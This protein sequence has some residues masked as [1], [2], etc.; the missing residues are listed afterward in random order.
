MK[1]YFLLFA[2]C[3]VSFSIQAKDDGKNYFAASFGIS[4][5]FVNM[6]EFESW[7]A[8]LKSKYVLSDFYKI[9]KS[10]I[11]PVVGF[12]IGKDKK[13]QTGLQLQYSFKSQSIKDSIGKSLNLFHRNLMLTYM[14]GY[15]LTKWFRVDAGLNLHN[16]VVNFKEVGNFYFNNR[17]ESSNYSIYLSP[18]IEL[19][20][21]KREAGISISPFYNLGINKFNYIKKGDVLA[22]QYAGPISSSVNSY[23]VKIQLVFR[24]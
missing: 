9:E 20:D 14:I 17:N 7:K 12:Y 2:I 23:G 6:P 3:L 11:M 5:A 13:M 10:N 19:L 24:K 16:N 4:T 18:T 22:T 1:N 15:N 21:K 8:S